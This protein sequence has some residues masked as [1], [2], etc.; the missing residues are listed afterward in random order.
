MTLKLEGDLDILK[1]YLYTENEAASL[2]NSK[3]NAWI[4]KNTN[5]CYKCQGQ[6]VTS[7]VIVTDNKPQQFPANS[8]WAA[9]LERLCC[10]DL[11]YGPMTLKLNRDL[12]ILKMYHRIK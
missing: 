8:F 7:S 2:R 10:C 1:M 12:D 3:L 11:D 9:R 4:V 6:N 5:I